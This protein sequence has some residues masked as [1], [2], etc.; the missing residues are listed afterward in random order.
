MSQGLFKKKIWNRF[1]T[2]QIYTILLSLKGLNNTPKIGN[3]TTG[4]YAKPKFVDRII[5]GVPCYRV[6]S[7]KGHNQTRVV[8]RGVTTCTGTRTRRNSI[9]ISKIPDYEYICKLMRSGTN[10]TDKYDN[11]LP[12]NRTSKMSTGKRALVL[13]K[14]C[15]VCLINKNLFSRHFTLVASPNVSTRQAE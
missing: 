12:A 4:L 1:A 9:F 3:C 10:C 14:H 2:F 11:W 8:G 5:D 6:L 15:E 13:V 7:A